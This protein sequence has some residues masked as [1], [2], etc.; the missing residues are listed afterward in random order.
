[1]EGQYVTSESART[2]QS[3]SKGPL[4]SGQVL[5]YSMEKLC[6]YTSEYCFQRGEG[7]LEALHQVRENSP[8]QCIIIP[9]PI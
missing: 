5:L 2:S 9:L 4:D 7:E 6:S 8:G 3:G 1:M